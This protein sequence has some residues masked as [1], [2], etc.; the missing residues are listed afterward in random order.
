MTLP[1][2]AL[3]SR[4]LIVPTRCPRC[5]RWRTRRRYA[6]RDRLR[7]RLLNVGGVQI[8][9]TGIVVTSTGLLVT[10]GTETSSA[11]CCCT[12]PKLCTACTGNLTVTFSSVTMAFNGCNVASTGC[13]AGQ[14]S[15]D[16]ATTFSGTFTLLPI[17][18]AGSCTWRLHQAYT[19]ITASRYP[20]GSLCGTAIETTGFI[21]IQVASGQILV[22][23]TSSIGAVDGPQVF[24]ASY[25]GTDDFSGFTKSNGLL[26]SGNNRCWDNTLSMNGAIQIAS[27][28]SVDVS[29]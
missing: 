17:G 16:G 26:S 21:F 20:N 24:G 6:P 12:G 9:D 11:T 14:S 19:T 27:G 29:C 10:D 28:G 3:P 25:T 8:S 13:A 4:Q 22:E 18:G 23:L 15:I 2:L 7:Q 1:P 5:G